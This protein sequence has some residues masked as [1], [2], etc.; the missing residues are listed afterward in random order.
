MLSGLQLGEFVYEQPGFTNIE[1]TFKHALTQE[2]AY[3]GLL[4]R[5]RQ[6]LHERVAKAIEAMLGDRTGEFVETL[7]YHYQRSSHAHRLRPASRP[8]GPGHLGNPV[9]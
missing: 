9:L 3:E 6:D 5:E 4:R 8:A 7:A 1:L 2:V